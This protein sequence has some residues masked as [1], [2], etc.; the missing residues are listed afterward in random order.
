MYSD[1]FS[2]CF[3]TFFSGASV[4]V[5]RECDGRAVNWLSTVLDLTW[6]VD[7]WMSLDGV[8]YQIRSTFGEESLFRASTMTGCSNTICVIFFPSET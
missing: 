2:S 8:T 5:G 4:G 6:F 3:P 7:E 1:V